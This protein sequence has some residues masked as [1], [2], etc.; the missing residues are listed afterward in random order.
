MKYLKPQYYDEFKCAADHCPDTCCAGWQI[1]IDEES[2]ENYQEIKGDFRERLMNG[3]DW[4]EGSFQQHQGRCSMLNDKNLCDLVTAC[5]EEALCE[6]CAR[7]PRH[8]E[9]YEGLRELSLSLS[10]PI[11]ARMILDRTETIQFQVTEDDEEDPLEDEFD[12]FDLFLFTQLEDARNAMFAIAQNRDMPMEDRLW[13]ILK[14]A[15]KMQS[16][17]DE[18]RLFDM[19]EIILQYSEW[20]S[21]YSALENG[22][23][24][25]QSMQEDGETEREV[26]KKQCYRCEKVSL[27]EKRFAELQRHFPIFFQLE[28][29]RDEWTDVI[30][31]AQNTLFADYDSYQE[32]RNAFLAEYGTDGTYHVEWEILQENLLM[33]FLYTYFCGAVY[34]DWIYS[35]AALSVFSVVF[36]SEFVMCRW[37]HADKHIEKQDFVE[38]A[39]RYAR[40][41]EHSDDN[42][43][44]LEEW[45]QENSFEIRGKED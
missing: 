3:I 12:N 35:K 22:L 11:A 32:I 21:L 37:V 13:M 19:D 38:L 27:E 26:E 15:G 9:E 8:V 34:D 31:E 17:V 23:V 40:E 29:L 1:M 4:R 10:C 20:E 41:V 33:F 28:R 6:T 43:N 2:L 18:D 42:L 45:L 14:M 5:G 36:V 7:Y 16:Y 44:L 39:Y 24:C 30:E 25:E